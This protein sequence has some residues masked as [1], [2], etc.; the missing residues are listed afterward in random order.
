MSDAVPVDGEALSAACR[1]PAVS[2]VV[3]AASAHLVGALDLPQLV[4]QLNAVGENLHEA[5]LGT[6]PFHDLQMKVQRAGF[7]LVALGDRSSVELDAFRHAA[8]KMLDDL[9]CVHALL[10]DGLDDVAL[11]TL[12]ATND[13]SEKLAADARKLSDEFTAAADD[14]QATLQAT[15][16]RRA[17]QE[18]RR[19]ALA[20]DVAEYRVLL[21]QARDS[22]TAS[23][24]GFEEAHSLY[25]EALRREAVAS[26]KYTT[27]QVAQ[28]VTAIGSVFSSR[29]GLHVV[30]LGGVSALASAFESEVMR[31]R[32]E[33]AVY[34]HERH[35]QRMSRLDLGKDVAELTARLRVA[36]EEDQVAEATVQS[37]EDAVSGLRVLSGIMLKAEVFWGQVETDLGRAD[38][39][40]LQ[41]MIESSKALPAE[42]RAELWTTDG[43]KRRAVAVYSPWVALQHVCDNYVER[44]AGTRTN[45]YDMLQCPGAASSPPSAPPTATAR[46]PERSRPRA[47][48]TP[49]QAGGDAPE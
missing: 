48:P 36:R 13:G 46:L 37:L 39:L 22:K 17:D 47:A 19:K 30:G 11:A 23:D 7:G 18:Q 40:A 15:L 26:M 3:Q 4:T 27:M 20:G 34:L 32:E 28:A 24:L 21:E 43:F 42:R 1:P 14:V 44:I 41:A 16:Q 6:A 12:R 45:L 38:S 49:G 35:K 10:V 2:R 25:E 9:E 8:G 31:V 29:P 5:Y 33:K